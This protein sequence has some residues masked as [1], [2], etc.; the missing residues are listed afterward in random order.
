MFEENVSNGRRSV[1][2]FTSQYSWLR[3]DAVS[4]DLQW[5]SFCDGRFGYGTGLLHVWPYIDACEYG[6]HAS[7]HHKGHLL[8]GL[9][10]WY[11]DFGIVSHI[12]ILFTITLLS[13]PSMAS[14]SSAPSS[15][16]HCSQ[17]TYNT[18]LST[19]LPPFDEG[20]SSHITDSCRL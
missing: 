2:F 1:R 4:Y 15:S 3:F 6:E 7:P 19:V 12:Y 11:V 17:V 8:T 13:D 20:T 14:T 5:L 16:G 9:P 18:T 10:G